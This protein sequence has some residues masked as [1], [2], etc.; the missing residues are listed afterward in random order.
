MKDLIYKIVRAVVKGLLQLYFGQI[1]VQGIENVPRN[2]PVLFLSNHQNAFL[3]TILIATACG[4]SP[5]FLTRASVFTNK[6]LKSIFTFFKMIPIYRI[7]D[8]IKSLKNNEQ[9]FAICTALL[10]KSQ[11]IVL[12]P[13]GN[14][15]LKR[16]VRPLSK[17]FTRIIFSSLEKFPDLDIYIV[18]IGVNYKSAANFPDKVA[19]IYGQPIRVLDVY[20]GQDLVRSKDIFLKLVFEQLTT[21]TTHIESEKN[22][23][24][25][26]E[27]LD[28]LGPDYLV[29]ENINKRLIPIT[30][31]TKIP[32]IKT[33]QGWFDAFSEFIFVLFNFP[34]VFAW[35]K[36]IKPKIKE[37]EFLSTMRFA[38]SV[39]TYPFYYLMLL[40]L[41]L[42]FWDIN[43]A[44]MIC[45]AVFLGN[46]TYT[47]FS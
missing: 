2:K 37:Q 17:G 35:R 20:N 16:R 47:K 9:T 40:I 29:P 14:H 18:P 8:G 7:R 41:G 46:L 19:V 4:R 26:I 25:I 5:F 1:V 31:S 38:F 43:I 22:Y 12:F 33:S 6:I 39:I 32:E 28:L 30:E 23:D 45:L 15:S 34:I 21:L 42:F 11:A 13:E 24:A 44:L 27:K 3:D 10:A 36:F